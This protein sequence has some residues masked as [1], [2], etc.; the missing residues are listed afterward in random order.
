[1]YLSRVRHTAIYTGMW[2]G[3]ISSNRARAESEKAESNAPTSVQRAASSSS[4]RPES[5]GRGEEEKEAFFRMMNTWFREFLRTNP[6]VQQPPRSVP[7][8]P[9]GIEPVR[10]ENTI[11]VLD[12]L[13][14]RLEEC[15]KCV[16]S[17]LKDSSYQWWHTLISV[18]I[19]DQ[20]S[21][22]SNPRSPTPSVA[23]AGSVDIV[24]ISK[25]SNLTSR[26]R[27]PRNPG[28]MSDSRGTRKDSTAKSEARAPAR[29]Y[30]IRAREDASAPNVIT[31]TFSLLYTDITALI[32]PSSTHS[33]ICMDLVFVKNLPVEFIEFVVKVSNPLGQYVMV[34]KV[35][36]NYSLMVR[37]YCFSA[38]LMLL[39]FDIFD[40]I[41]GMDWLTQHDS[42]VNCKQKYIVLKCQNGELLRI[43]FDKLDGLSNVISTI[44]AQK[45][46]RKG[47]DAYLAYVLD[48]KLSESKIKSVSIVCEFPDVFPVELPR[49]LPVREVEFSLDLVLGTT[50]ISI[51]P[52][53]MA[54][55]E[56][57]ELKEKLQEL[58]D[59]DGSLRLRI[60]YKQ[61]NK[62][63]IKNKY[64]WPRMDDLFD[65]FKGATVFSKIHLCSGYQLRVKDSDVLK[66]SF[67]TRDEHYEF[68]VMLFGLTNAPAVF[69]DLINRIFI[70]YLDRFLV[71]FIDDILV[72][73]QDEN[74]HVD[75][76]R[77]VLQTLRE[78]QLY[79]K[80]SKWEFWLRKVSFLG[81]IVSAEG[82]VLIQEGKVIAYASR[83]L[84]PH[85]K[86]YPIHDLELAAIVFALKIWRHYLWP[87]L[88]KDYDLDIDYHLGKANAV[89]DALSR[90]SLFALYLKL[91]I[92]MMKYKLNGYNVSQTSIQNFILDLMVVCYL[93][94]V[95]AEHQ[96]KRDMPF[97]S[98]L[99]I[100]KVS[101]FILVR[102]DF[103]LDRLAELYV[104]EIIRLYGVPVSI[105]FYRDLL[106]TSRF[107]NKSQEALGTQLHFSTA[108]HLQTDGQSERVI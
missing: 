93:E 1:M 16:V 102:L 65:Q 22:H 71:V 88:L 31:G 55:T 89:A 39:P 37:G 30:A 48:T 59:R 81:H 34:D 98:S 51:T 57:K 101:H 6:T 29:T 86:N 75:H 21:Q 32:D 85:E 42:V 12:E 87:E 74:D 41:L 90:K 20:G 68:L 43:E 14:C 44:S 15:L 92:V 69:M 56:L 104:S 8:M 46:I 58:T 100:N 36:K 5:E 25:P 106:F 13:S 7:N 99:T 49:L 4:R 27:P 11:K 63:T 45:Y 23:S 70:P 97:G 47:Y 10:T 9:P 79:T 67:R 96:E 33:Y 73:S 40:V 72:Y 26:S 91:R 61:L 28:N 18:G 53:R 52:Y 76:L 66:T 24:Q 95:K 84:K 54:L 64:P 19:K 62:V 108:F 38:D 105:I 83:Q 50:P 17:L 82:C 2:F 3:L 103:S 94:Q 77:I 107:R 35:Y 60:E 80:F 78:K